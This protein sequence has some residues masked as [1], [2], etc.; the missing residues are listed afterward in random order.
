MIGVKPRKG[1]PLFPTERE[2]ELAGEL[3]P[4]PRRWCRPEGPMPEPEPPE[5]RIPVEDPGVKE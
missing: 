2:V 4:K 1:R 5:A 3:E